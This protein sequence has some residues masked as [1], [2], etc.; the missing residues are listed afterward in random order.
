MAI[1]NQIGGIST[2]GL[3]GVLK[4]PLDK[5]FGTTNKPFMYQYPANLG[6]DPSRM[7]MV[8]FTI[9]EI[10]PKKFD[11]KQTISG[12]LETSPAPTGTTQD[13]EARKKDI[14]SRSVNGNAVAVKAASIAKDLQTFLK[15]EKKKTATVVTLY[16]PD[17]LTMN[18]HADY[19]ELT[20]MEA[21]NG[22]NRVAGAIGSLAE[23]L[24]KGGFSQQTMINA[25]AK[26]VDEYGPEAGLRLVDRAAGTNITDLGLKAMGMAVN[27]QL[28]LVYKGL[29]FRTFSMDFI[30][31]P[32]SQ[33]ESD[34][35]SAI[36]NTFIYAAHPT[37]TGSSGMYF[38]PP[39][40]FNMEFLMA[41][42]GSFSGMSAMLQKAGNSI[43][44]GV[45][46]GN[47]I[48]NKLNG[49]STGMQNDR[50]YK[51]GD[52][53]LEDV[54]VDYAPNGWAAYSGGAP[55]QTRLTLSFKEIDI[56]DR[57]R[58]TSDKPADRVR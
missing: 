1:I 20:L 38:T 29:G 12:L 43:I 21:T 46:V 15:P 57:T 25:A 34:Q 9:S 35:V 7:H 28:Q 49:A 8:K 19:S 32:K 6:N 10:I 16:M 27:P 22:L 2:G 26:T 41:Q 53:V 5:L 11:I 58:M 14:I 55:V 17:S 44:P 50:L 13:L 4:G 33:E 54:S 30:F 36:I 18:Y 40:I 3:T 42:T 23:D 37:V 56:L 31:T 47:L 45:P 39:S 51:V 48:A 24:M 52:C